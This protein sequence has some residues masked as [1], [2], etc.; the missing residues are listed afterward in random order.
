MRKL[1]HIFIIASLL[2]ASFQG[3]AQNSANT[4]K[5]LRNET[6]LTLLIGS[7]QRG[8]YAQT[9]FNDLLNKIKEK[10]HHFSS[11]EKYLKHIYRY[12]HKKVLKSYKKYVTLS[13]T[14]SKKGNYDCLTGTLLYSLI[15][16]ELG[17][18]YTIREFNYHVAL[19][20]HL[21]SNQL[22]IESTD[23]LDGFIVGSKAINSRIANYKKEDIEAKRSS[24]YVFTEVM[25]N[26]ISILELTGLHYYNQAL[27]Y[28]NREEFVIASFK[29][30]KAY[31]LYPS[32]RIRRVST[33]IRGEG[34]DDYL[35]TTK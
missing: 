34:L 10:E 18:K 30:D 12:V 33:L 24:Q 15:L 22:M 32:P 2:S 20:I 3:F 21:E 28:F 26:K 23:P 27:N 35:A 6:I 11:D 1:V 16:D 17:F 25:D 7:D 13:E 29:I 14:L 19:V 8:D 5:D 31:S 4:E 9:R